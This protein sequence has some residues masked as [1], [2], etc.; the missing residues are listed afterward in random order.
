MK[1]DKYIN[2][3]DREPKNIKI[4]CCCRFENNLP[5]N[6]EIFDLNDIDDWA[7]HKFHREKVCWYDITLIDKAYEIYYDE[8]ETDNP[9][10]NKEIFIDECINNKNSNWY[11]DY[12]KPLLR[13]EK[14]KR[15]I[16][17]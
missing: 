5:L 10:L 14:L 2:Y 4:I 13:E 1:N 12:Y 7:K 17:D 8:V 3:N 6:Y 9:I 15:I 11:K 16:E